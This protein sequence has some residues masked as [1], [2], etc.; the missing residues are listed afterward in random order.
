MENQKKQ[1]LLKKMK[2]PFILK[3]TWLSTLRYAADAAHDKDFVMKQVM[4]KPGTPLKNC[5][6]IGWSDC[7]EEKKNTSSK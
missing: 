4:P 1:N 5:R 6:K 3:D 2:R 7:G